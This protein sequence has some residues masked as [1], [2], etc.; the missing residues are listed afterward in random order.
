LRGCVTEQVLNEND[1][2][3]RPMAN[4][5]ITLDRQELE[6][7]ILG[8]IQE[9][10]KLTKVNL[11]L[12]WNGLPSGMTITVSDPVRDDTKLFDVDVDDD[13]MNRSL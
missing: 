4:V 12:E 2:K 9:R 13:N 3:G 10:Y 7:I 1:R 6:T 11:H 5:V 8:E